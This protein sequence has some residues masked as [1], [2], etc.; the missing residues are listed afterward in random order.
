MTEPR[1]GLQ[2]V[3]RRAVADAVGER[4]VP[5]HT[6]CL[7][8]DPGVAVERYERLR[9]AFADT[10]SYYAV[11]ANP[12]PRLIRRLVRAGAFFDVASPA[13]IALCLAEGADPSRLS[14]GNTVKKAS[15]IRYAYRSGVRLFVFDS[16]DELLKLA[17]HAPGSAVFCRLLASSAGAQWP[18]SGKFGCTP[19]MAVDLL[20]QA[21]RLGLRP[22]GVSFHVG[23][24]QLDPGRWEPSVA[25][26]A[27]VSGELAAAGIELTM[28]NVGGGFPVEYTS[29]VPP[30]ERYAEAITAAVGRH[31]DTR[32]RLATEP[33]RYVAAVAG[34]LRTEVVLVSRKTFDDDTRW[35]YL[36]VGRF[37]GLAETEGEA[38]RYRLVTPHDGGPDGA[39]VLAGPTC[40]S[41]DILYQRAAYRLPLALRQGDTVDIL[42]AGAY[43][44]TYASVGFNG[45]PPLPTVC[46]GDDE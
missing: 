29:P 17:E 21:P 42:A 39:V 8:L 18:L 1:G 32:P 16:Q 12:E 22:V 24:Q 41:V 37:G 30:I 2:I 45:F 46:I 9:A 33:G 10:D 23:S 34:V 4:D 35:V 26:A 15:D 38:I 25:T 44:T 6:P 3:E 28:L 19:E 13:E 14:Y 20:T 40:D 31:F 5:A 27:W 36:D 7:Y 43:T 11:K